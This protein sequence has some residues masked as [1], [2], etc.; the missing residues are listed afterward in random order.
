MAARH[1]TPA[2]VLRRWPYSES[3]L[4]VRVLTPRQGTISLVAKGVNKLKSGSLGVLDVWSL[5]QI[6]YGGPPDAEMQ[7]LYRSELLDR[8]PGLSANPDRLAAAALL[9][10]LAELGSPAHQSSAEMFLFL[11]ESLQ[12]LSQG[13]A[14]TDF[15]LISA[16]LR[17]L[18]LLGISP[19]LRHDPP[20]DLGQEIWFHTASGGI[21]APGQPRPQSRAH[22]LSA[23]QLSFFLSESAA[24]LTLRE[25]DLCLTIMGEFLAYHLDR[26]PKSWAALARRH[27]IALTS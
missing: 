3:S 27:Q 14:E 4:I 17:V 26:P 21:L 9:G 8:M 11:A 2:I 19:I 6:E 23:A 10:E 1:K 13:N 5:V 25:H 20:H 15:S 18:K 16:I 24:K 7:T 22:Q 12:A